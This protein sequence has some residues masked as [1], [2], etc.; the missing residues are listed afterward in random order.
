M[1]IIRI[2]CRVNLNVIVFVRDAWKMQ[3]V[4]KMYTHEL[5]SSKPKAVG[6][7][8]LAVLLTCLY[9]L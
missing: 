2:I 7:W 4:K 3:D 1:Y 5:V 8:P 9:G 6:S